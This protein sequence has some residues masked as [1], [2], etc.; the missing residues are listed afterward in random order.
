MFSIILLVK[1]WLVA[2]VPGSGLIYGLENVLLNDSFPELFCLA[3]NRD[4]MVADLRSVSNDMA[5]WDINFTKLV[6]DWEVDFVSS[7]FN[8]LYSARVG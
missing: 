8:V 5:H 4:A 3:R 7:F 6:D 1:R 2:L